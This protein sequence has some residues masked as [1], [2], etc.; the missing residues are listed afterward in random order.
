M[1]IRSQTIKKTGLGYIHF[2]PESIAKWR[3]LPVKS[4]ALL[5][6]VCI[7]TPN[8]T[9]SLTHTSTYTCKLTVIHDIYSVYSLLTHITTYMLSLTQSPDSHV[10]LH[11]WTYVGAHVTCNLHVRICTCKLTM[12]IAHVNLHVWIC[13]CKLTLVVC[14]CSLAHVNL[15][16]STYDVDLHMLTCTCKLGAHD[17]DLHMLTCTWIHTSTC[18]CEFARHV[19]LRRWF[20]RVN[21]H[22]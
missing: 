12:G 10:N 14:A 2:F 11:M 20:S 3:G 4:L 8:Y 7:H 18:P 6:L 13:T 15:H 21:L 5:H 22:M 1:R 17:G 9:W 19:N 16:L